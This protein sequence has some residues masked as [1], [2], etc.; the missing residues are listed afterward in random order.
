[1]QYHSFQFRRL[2][3]EIFFKALGIKLYELNFIFIA[4]VSNEG[5]LSTSFSAVA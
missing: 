2:L 4:I 1:M 3:S 5:M